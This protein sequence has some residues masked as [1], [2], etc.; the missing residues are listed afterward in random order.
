MSDRDD[1]VRTFLSDPSKRSVVYGTLL[2]DA[3][4]TWIP[5]GRYHYQ[6][7]HL[8]C[9]KDGTCYVRIKH[10]ED[11]KNLVLHKHEFMKEI[12]GKIF[13]AKPANPKWQTVYGF[14]TKTSL[15]WKE[16]YDEF[17]KDA[18]TTTN[19]KGRVQK[20]KR[21]TREILNKLDDRGL[22]WWIMDDGCYS[23]DNSGFGFFR[24]ST[25]GYTEEE[26]RMIT[27]WLRDRYG[28]KA[29]LHRCHRKGIGLATYDSH[30][31]CIGQNEFEPL[32][33]VLEPFVIPE[34]RSKLGIE[35]PLALTG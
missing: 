19:A 6:N 15:V 29:N 3:T 1:A 30:I 12:S 25:Q 28:V 2:G 17:Y 5:P 10:A 35:H 24:L 9:G 14:Y 33:A 32:K 22:A 23:H 8:K 13:T 20:F 7:D 27:V 11:Q 31:L 26:C 21:V 34:L 18:R 16:I 4:L